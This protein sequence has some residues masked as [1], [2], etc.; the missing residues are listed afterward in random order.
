MSKPSSEAT[1]PVVDSVLELIGKTPLVRIAHDG[2]GH[3]WA[4]CEHMNPGGSVK[5][6]I[7]LAML[8]R[9]REEGRIEPGSVVVEPT[10]GNTGIGLA[11]V[12]AIEQYQLELTMPESMSLE[13]RQLLEAYGAKIHFTPAEQVMDGAVAEAE[14]IAREKDAFIPQQFDNPENPRVHYEET[15]TEI[16]EALP[17][18]TLGVFVSAVGTGGTLT[19]VGRRLREVFPDLQIVA[20][21]PTS[22][23]VLAGGKPGPSKIQGINAGFVPANYDAS[24]VTS[25][26]HVSDREAYDEKHRLA[27]EQGLLVGMSAAANVAAARR[28][29]DQVPAGQCIVTILCDTGERYFS[30]DEHF[31]ELSRE[32][33]PS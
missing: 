9:A 7:C 26:E 33:N 31:S 4:K 18:A 10:S 3:I 6:R 23:P 16:L 21:E 22:S 28:Y 12:S 1:A 29:A 5:D 32:E 13:R 24:L 30:L 2:P 11:L 19:G 25:V 27:I 8:E 20:V 17:D 15:A 14:R